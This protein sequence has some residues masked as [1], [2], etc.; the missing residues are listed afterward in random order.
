[1]ASGRR[2]LPKKVRTESFWQSATG[3]LTRQDGQAPVYIWQV[4]DY[5]G[6]TLRIALVD[7]DTRTGCALFCSGFEILNASDFEAGEFAGFMAGMA[8]KNKLGQMSRYDTRHFTG[9]SN[10]VESFS[11]S[12]LRDCEMLYSTFCNHFRHK[13]FTV[14]DPDTKLML[15]IFD[16]QAG[17]E[18]YLGQKVSPLVTGIYHKQSNRLVTY[19]YGTNDSYLA[20]K[21]R[22]ETETRRNSSDL[23]RL[24]NLEALS[25][26]AQDVRAAANVGTMMHETA[27]QLSFN[28]GLFN[29]EGDVPLWAAE[30]LACYCECTVN[31]AWQ[32]IGELNPERLAA[33]AAMVREA[34]KPIPLKDLVGSDDWLRSQ[35]DKRRLLLGYA[36]SWALFRMLMEQ[37][38]RALE[39]YLQSIYS[40]RTNDHRL[41]DFCAIFGRDLA[42][43]EW[44]YQQYMENLAAQIPA[45][46]H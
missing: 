26:K 23:E 30:G 1:M 34:R 21:R 25:R 33:L 38:P 14:H 41:E 15:A 4:A 46:K 3:I 32:G 36:Q 39:K 19:D 22:A 9:I 10:S 43:L 35:T 16:S 12:R 31:G 20:S 45:A 7:Q 17:F 8:Q 37:Q 44:K 42:N 28:C 18:A 24:S 5:V 27:H 6:Q 29:R 2:I 13:G 40:R 11:E